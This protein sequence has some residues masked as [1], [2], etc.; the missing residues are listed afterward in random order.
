MARR[1]TKTFNPLWLFLIAPTLLGIGTVLR[2]TDSNAQ[3]N[4]QLL[5]DSLQASV[6][7]SLEENHSETQLLQAESR[8]TS[9]VCFRAKEKT[10]IAKGQTYNLAE[11]STIC[12]QYGNTALINKYGEVTQLAR[13]TNQEIIKRFYGW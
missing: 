9:G 12:D 8:Y 7:T 5:K 4:S 1:K 6:R 2:S 10:R 3:I 13:T 11:N